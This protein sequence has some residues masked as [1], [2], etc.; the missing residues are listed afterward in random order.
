MFAIFWWICHFWQLLAKFGNFCNPVVS[1]SCHPVILSSCH[2]VIFSSL[3][4]V[5]LSFCHLVSLAAC[6][7][8]SLWAFQLVHLG[9]CKLLHIRSMISFGG[10]LA[11]CLP[12]F[13]PWAL[14]SNHYDFLWRARDGKRGFELQFQRDALNLQE[15]HPHLLFPLGHLCPLHLPS[16]LALAYSP[17][18][19][20]CQHQRPG[21]PP[22][23]P[24]G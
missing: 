2:L 22:C 17:S 23:P 3:H 15:V 13:R 4:L 16:L 5:I 7:F 6:Q 14:E 21:L 20:S 24:F 19:L 9:A 12:C 1:S 10:F 8:V 11:E 18:K